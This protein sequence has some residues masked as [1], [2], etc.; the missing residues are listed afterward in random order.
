MLREALLYCR[1]EKLSYLVLGK[2]S[3]CLF[4]D[5][6]FDGLVILNKICFAKQEGTRLCAGA[7]YSFSLLG[8]QTARKGWS[9]LE[10]AAGIPG[11]VGGA[12]YM[13]AGANGMETCGCLEEVLYVT[14]EGVVETLPKEQ[15]RFGYRT[16]SF[17]ERGGAIASATFS[18]TP[19]Q[20]ARG[21]QL[22]IIAYRTRTQPYKEMSAGCLFRNPPCGPSAGQLIEQCGLK[23]TRVG[24]AEISAR[25]ANF[26]INAG[27]ATARDVQ[28]LARLVQ[29]AVA[30]QTGVVLEMEVRSVPY[31]VSR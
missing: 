2:G 12:V 26:L 31:H 7:G 19:S 27:G 1:R 30:D 4:D 28:E 8:A 17:Q 3:N 25:H 11:S 14:E 24:G 20:G 22:D 15:I 29:S 10:F 6:G 23:G 9:G 13:N 18:L 16:T 5:R 21:K